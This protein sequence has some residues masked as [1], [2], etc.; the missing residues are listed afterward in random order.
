M[1]EWL[2]SGTEDDVRPRMFAESE[3]ARPFALATIT[4]ADG[5]PRPVGAQM[6][7]T[8]DRT[9]GFLSGGCIEADVAVHAR[10]ALRD[11]RPRTLVYGRGSPF[12]DMRLPCG[13]RIE[14]FLERVGAGDPAMA[15]L[16]RLTEARTP[17]LWESDGRRRACRAE[18]ERGQMAGARLRRR[19]DPGQRMVVIGSDP[20]AL[21]MAALA[22]NIGWDTILVAPFGP[23]DDP[24]FGI[25]CDRR[26]PD[27]ALAALRPDR[28][29][30]IA[31]A[32]HDLAADEEALTAALRSGSGYVGVLG[33]RRKHAERVA[34]LRTAGLDDA[35]IA[36]LK[37]PIGLPI[38]A[39]SP[40]EIAVA[41]AGEIIAHRSPAPARPL[42]ERGVAD[43]AAGG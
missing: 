27:A 30:A 37:S 14:V 13:G 43:A 39:S 12:I 9:W 29:T 32:T 19:Y 22:R 42:A 35:A 10:Q 24:P 26:P 18:L 15:G 20:F 31:V 25:V 36:H 8:E 23:A 3:A 16:R 28:W 33:S 6:V 4:A 41:V 40:W 38:G 17:A 5:G 21:A 11:G 7:V 1:A 34:G 2:A